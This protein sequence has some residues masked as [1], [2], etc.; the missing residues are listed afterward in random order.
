MRTRVGYAGGSKANPSYYSLGDHSETVQIDYDPSRVSYQQLLDIFWQSHRP[1]SPAYSRQYASIIFYHDEA[2]QRMALA[3]K[4]QMEA[5][6]G[7]RLYTEIRPYTAFYP[8]EDYHQKYY[9]RNVPALF[10]EYE[11][12]YP[13]P[14]DL[15]NSTAVARVNGFIGGHSSVAEV[16]AVLDELGLSPQGQQQLLQIARGKW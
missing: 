9:L 13:H 8:A 2:Q 15:V 14:Q 6:L 11:A 16:Q 5:R 10:A 1:T 12:I 4:A 7:T 3:S